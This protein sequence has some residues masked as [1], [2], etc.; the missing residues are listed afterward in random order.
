MITHPFYCGFPFYQSIIPFTIPEYLINLSTVVVGF[1]LFVFFLSY[2]NS[3][4][5]KKKRKNKLGFILGYNSCWGFLHSMGIPDTSLT[6]LL[7]KVKSWISWGT[8]GLSPSSL[9]GEFQIG[10]SSLRMCCECNT[11]FTGLSSG[12]HCLSCGRWLCIKCA[13]AYEAPAV[14]ESSDVKSNGDFRDSIKSCKFCIG[15]HVKHEGGRKNSEKVHPS[16]SPRESPEPPSPSFSGE[17]IRSDNLS[18]Y[19]ESRDSVY[20]PLAVTTRSMTSFSAHPSLLSHRNSPS[21]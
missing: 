8:N 21:R 2:S 19:L 6:D 1:L 7:D 9:P 18:P 5:K 14:I 20:S 13:R 3:I 10:Y 11:S 12:H 4:Y 17:S 15:L 16:E